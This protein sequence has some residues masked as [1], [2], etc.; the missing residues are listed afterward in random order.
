VDRWVIT[1]ATKTH[2]AQ[3]KPLYFAESLEQEPGRWARWRERISHIVV[4]DFPENSADP[5]WSIE[6][7]QRDMIMQ[8]LVGCKDSDIIMISDVDEIPR[9]E[10]V[11]SYRTEM[12]LCALEMRLLYGYMNL[13][14]NEPWT[15]TRLLPY[16]I[17]KQMTPCAVRYNWGYDKPNYDQT[18]PNAGWH[19]SFMGGPDEWIKKLEDTPHQEY[20]KPEFKNRETL[21]QR[22]LHGD[23]IL[24]R[25]HLKYRWVEVDESFPQAVREDLSRWQQRGFILMHPESWRFI[26]SVKD[27]HPEYFHDREVLE[28]GSLN[29]NGTVRQF[30][31]NCQY[32]GIDLGEG[33]CVDMVAHVT[34]LATH[35]PFDVVISSEALEHDERWMESLRAMYALLKPD[36]LLLITCAGPTRPEHGTTRTDTYSSPFT[37]DYYRNISKEDFMEILPPDKFSEC[38]IGYERGQEDLNFWGVKRVDNVVPL[39]KPPKLG[40]HSVG[41][42]TAEVC[43]K[44]RYHTTLPLALSA[45]INQTVKPD[46]LVIYD[47]SEQRIE[48]EQLHATSPYNGLFKMAADKGIKFVVFGTPR[49]GQVSNHQHCLDTAETE[50]IWRV[51][52]DEIPEPDC[53]K[54]LLNTFRD[55]GRGGQQREVGAVAGLVHHPA[56]ISPLPAG[57]DG[58]L[59]DLS[60]GVN[61]QWHQWNGQIREVDH[62]YSTFLYRVDAARAA[63]GYPRDLSPVGHRE[64]TIFTHSMKRAGYKILVTPYA[65]TWHLRESGGGI[66]SFSDNSLWAHDEEIFQQ[67]LK[68]WNVDLQAT[69]LVVLDLGLGDHFICKGIFNDLR[70]KFPDR[71]W[72]LATCF[73]DVFRDEDVTQISIAD[74]KLL[75]GD[76]YDNYSVYKYAWERNLERPMA[77]V[78]MEFFSK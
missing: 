62:L 48:A 37:T 9:T 49:A 78:M 8:A 12:G 58:S 17:M 60:I 77:E 21:F 13:E 64:E 56:S 22:A 25:E 35:G 44:D 2:G 31:S 28:V 61:L 52:D 10:A 66:R 69:K 5:F 76:R 16:S 30:F 6:R 67:Y 18:I 29:I 50:Y 55:Y 32:T 20:N 59:N 7:H 65:K 75:L 68:V 45:I 14:G 42:V 47:D 27:A 38:T 51:D 15:W 23:D 54:E 43:T 33:D 4:S 71:K 40:D 70:R 57:I 3:D 46:K 1:E 72:T 74:A 53:L 39:K 26:Q 73:P 34:E 41:T 24:G 36:G 11:Q 19:F 63:G